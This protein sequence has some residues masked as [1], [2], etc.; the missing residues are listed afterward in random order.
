MGEA[1]EVTSGE[2][3][4][5]PR[6]LLAVDLGL[7]LGVAVYGPDGRL[8]RY[9]SQHYASRGKLKDAVY[10]I[11]S[12]AP[13]IEVLVLEGD[14]GLGELF[15]RLA[16]KRGARVIRTDAHQW[17]RALMPPRDRRS[18]AGAKETAD[19]LARAVIDWS[20][21]KRP[22]SL[23]HDAAEAILIGLWGALEVGWLEELPEALEWAAG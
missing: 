23:R 8:E 5:R 11:M 12:E 21:A 15:A 16:R 3:G 20:G 2:E 17:R 14:R 6:S 9:R 1:G 7:R 19:G 10:G 4:D 18:G 13:G 22:T